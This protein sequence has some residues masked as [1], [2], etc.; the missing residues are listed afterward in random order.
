MSSNKLKGN[1]IIG[2]VK[3]V[4]NK[5][6]RRAP[7]CPVHVERLVKQ[8]CR[9]L[10][11]PSDRRIFTNIEYEKVGAEI[12]EDLSPAS[13]I[14]GVK[15]VPVE[16]LLPERSYVFFSHVI[17]AQPENMELLDSILENN[18]RLFDYETITVDGSRNK[19]RLVAF[20][21]FAGRAGMISALRGLGERM[22]CLGY[23]T[24]FLNIGSS[25]MYPSL[26][27]AKSAVRLVGGRIQHAGLPQDFSPLVFG[28]TGNGN[29]SQ[30]AQEVFEELPHEWISPNDLKQLTQDGGRSDLVYGCVIEEEHMVKRDDDGTG[31]NFSRNEYYQHP[32]KYS[33]IFH[34]HIVPYISC[35]VN[36]TY[37]DHRYPRLITKDQIN[38]QHMD[39]NI[40]KMM[41]VADISC[42]IEGSVEFLTKSSYIEQPFFLY[43][44]KNDE[45]TESLE[46]NGILMCGV[47]ILPSELPNESSMHFGDAMFDFVMPLVTSDGTLPYEEQVHDLPKALH[48]ACIASNGSLTPSF[49]YIENMRAERERNH[50]KQRFELME[51][52]AGNTVIRVT[53]HLF[54][55]GFIN[56]T[57]DIIED[58]GGQFYIVEMDVRPNSE[59]EFKSSADIQISVANGRDGL[60][61]IMTKLDALADVVPKAEAVIAEMPFDYCKGDFSKTLHGG[62]GQEQMIFKD[63]PSMSFT[64]N[65]NSDE[66]NVS[67]GR[68]KAVVLGS[69]LVAKPAV[70]YLS[71]QNDVVLLSSIEEEA[72]DIIKGV[73]RSHVQYKTVDVLKEIDLVHQE[74]K[75]AD[76]VLSL[77]PATMHVPIAK[78]CI[79]S[80]KPL[81]TAS[82]VN[83]EMQQLNEEAS[84]ASIPILCEMGLDPGM[85]HMSAMKVID[86]IHHD[87][88]SVVHFSSLCGGLPAPEAANNPLR[89]KFSWSPKGVLSAAKNSAQYRENGQIIQV[90]GEQLL[91]SAKAVDGFPT[92]SLEQLPNRD[93]LPYGELY[94]IHDEAETVYRGTLRYAG[95]SK[96]MNEISKTGLFGTGNMPNDI[97]SWQELSGKLNITNT[98]HDDDA[99]ACLKWL[100]VFSENTVH[101]SPSGEVGDAFCSLLEERLA[102]G[103]D[104]RD[105]V[106]MKHDF[107]VSHGNDMDNLSK[108]TSIF[109]GYGDANG[110]SS[111]AKTVGY[112]IA[113]GAQLILDDVVKGKGVLIPTTPDI[114]I[115]GLSLLEREGI[116]F[117]EE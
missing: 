65:S 76:V 96:I 108:K 111:M 67:N 7:L 83:D 102:Y 75:N 57:L 90:P 63:P 85:D 112:T 6:E 87:G 11:Q 62:V 19:P 68:K 92:L 58:C 26:N 12:T 99:L 106:L 35:L 71:R 13:V 46:G 28:F 116:V 44:P 113:I 56:K 53:G 105:M 25:Y 60:K 114:Y 18:I 86:E 78:L 31:K 49:S 23:S 34:D 8:G 103:N 45:T 89:Y 32:E 40:K 39:K 29:V 94:G 33:P 15:Q 51:E 82:Y 17:K 70:E 9:V 21:G 36:C 93:S 59:T 74:I 66:S 73:G 16:D 52:T 48:G 97:E 107:V 64:G 4:Y 50:L 95:W 110:D 54:D 20:G 3:E 81:V 91:S 100:G 30:G 22:L 61:E 41:A 2:I 47:D 42:D 115:P 27:D 77:L 38:E 43:N 55:S 1:K 88:G 117:H 79:K 80:C 5:W 101:N 69:G 104:E 84:D 24:P 98:I 109:I 37:W 72:I 10:V 14:F